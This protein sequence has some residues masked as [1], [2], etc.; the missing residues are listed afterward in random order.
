MLVS[1]E[2]EFMILCLLAGVVV[3]YFGSTNALSA[4]LFFISTRNVAVHQY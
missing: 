4:K 2:S 1:A 3:K